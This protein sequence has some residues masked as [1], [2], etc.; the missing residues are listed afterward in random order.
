MTTGSAR[1]GI[2][3]TASNGTRHSGRITPASIA[4]ASVTG[5]SPTIRPRGFQSPVM[6]TSTPANTN[7]P[8][9]AAKPPSGNPEVASSAALGV[10]HATEIGIRF[11]RL[12]TIPHR[13]MA[14]ASAIKPDVACSAVAPT[15]LRPC[16]TIAKEL[17]K[18]TNAERM[19]A[20]VALAEKEEFIRALQHSVGVNLSRLGNREVTRG[21]RKS[22]YNANSHAAVSKSSTSTFI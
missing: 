4:C 14:I 12:K 1:A 18:P 20:L 17:A 19:P 3:A 13:P 11:Q 2:S 21:V 9:P 6:T 22:T 15:P 16:K 7:A 10:D 5:I 8:T